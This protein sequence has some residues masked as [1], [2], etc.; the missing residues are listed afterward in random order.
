[1]GREVYF[2]IKEA[3]NSIELRFTRDLVGKIASVY[4][5]DEFLFSATIG[6]KGRI[7]VTKTSEIG[8]E[9]LKAIFGRKKIKVIV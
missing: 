4:V 8:R 1:M 7:K 9:L 2:E 3:G 5:E 6:K